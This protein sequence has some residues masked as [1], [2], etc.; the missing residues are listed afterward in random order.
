M[1]LIAVNLRMCEIEQVEAEFKRPLIAQTFTDMEFAG[2]NGVYP[3]LWEKASLVWMRL[4]GRSKDFEV[5]TAISAMSFIDHKRALGV[6]IA[7][8][9][10]AQDVVSAVRRVPRPCLHVM[11]TDMDV[12]VVESGRKG[13]LY[14][15]VRVDEPFKFSASVGDAK[16]YSRYP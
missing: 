13:R 14:S 3:D 10:V 16:M 7:P 8:H 12:I 11:Y 4:P 5:Q 1:S 2:L 9:S 15:P 6:V